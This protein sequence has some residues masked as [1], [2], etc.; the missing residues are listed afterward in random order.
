V[1]G[2]ISKAECEFRTFHFIL[3][4]ICTYKMTFN[5]VFQAQD[6]LSS[7]ASFYST[8]PKSEASCKM[9]Q[10]YEFC[11]HFCVSF[12]FERHF[13]ALSWGYNATKKQPMFK[14]KR[15]KKITPQR[16]F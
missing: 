5:H 2:V 12:N 9:S 4:R 15:P 3:N 10:S 14:K 8:L 6:Y 13:P 11:T 7:L 1:Q 16:K